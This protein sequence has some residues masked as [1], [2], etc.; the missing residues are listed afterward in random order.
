M[1]LFLTTRTHPPEPTLIPQ[2]VTQTA[3]PDQTFT[4]QSS[5]TI[6]V[7]GTE[8]AAAWVADH[9]AAQLRLSTGFPL[10]VESGAGT[11]TLAT[12]GPSELGDEGYELR[13]DDAAVTVT[14]ATPEG[15]FRGVPDAAPAAA[16]RGRVA[17]PCSP[18]RGQIAGRTIA[19]ARGSPY[20]GVML[21]VAR[22]FFTVDEVKRLHRPRRRCTRS[23]TCTCT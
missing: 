22:H 9:L 18:A 15:L 23:T 8:E 7:V 20:R 5:A 11:I 19:D 17:R 12:N 10:P 13:V 16:R 14:A 3:L 6:G 1:R 21:D 4:L 2:P